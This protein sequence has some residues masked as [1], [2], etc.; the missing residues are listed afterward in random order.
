MMPSRDSVKGSPPTSGTNTTAAG[1]LG[2]GTLSSRDQ[3]EL[4]GQSQ[5]PNHQTLTE[6][7]YYPLARFGSGEV[8]EEACRK[9]TR[10]V[11]SLDRQATQVPRRWP[12]V[13]IYIVTWF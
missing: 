4:F 3:H 11:G 8:W 12:N 9:V 6:G 1:E 10:P 7:V 13:A 2:G 5:Q